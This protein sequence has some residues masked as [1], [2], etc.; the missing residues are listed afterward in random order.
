MEKTKRQMP[1]PLDVK[2]DERPVENDSDL[3][4]ETGKP[5]S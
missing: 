1:D 3:H 4:P 2:P 5:P